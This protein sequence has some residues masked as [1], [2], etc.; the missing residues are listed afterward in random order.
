MKGVSYFFI[1]VVCT[2]QKFCIDFILS[3]V[4]IDGEKASVYV[5]MLQNC[6]CLFELYMYNNVYLMHNG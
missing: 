5:T 3:K 6:T 2:S 4:L 1:V